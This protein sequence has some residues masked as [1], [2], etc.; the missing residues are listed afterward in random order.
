MPNLAYLS[1]MISPWSRL[2]EAIRD[3]WPAVAGDTL[4]GAE[5]VYPAV[6]AHLAA[7]FDPAAERAADHLAAGSRRVLDLGVGAAP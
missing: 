2:T 4:L 7:G 1:V 3:D 6:V 5:P